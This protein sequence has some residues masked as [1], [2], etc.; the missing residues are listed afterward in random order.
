MTQLII[1]MPKGAEVFNIQISFLNAMIL[2]T[3]NKFLAINDDNKFLQLNIECSLSG[4]VNSCYF[5]AK[6]WYF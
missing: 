3:A 5:D 4:T 6:R 2:N 1:I